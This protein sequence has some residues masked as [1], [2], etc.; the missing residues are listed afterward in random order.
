MTFLQKRAII[1]AVDL[2]DSA[3][4]KYSEA[5]IARNTEDGN[6]RINHTKISVVANGNLDEAK[7]WLQAIIDD[8]EA[9]EES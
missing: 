1:A 7:D 8:S 5:A 4:K 6:C 3:K 9:V 2:I